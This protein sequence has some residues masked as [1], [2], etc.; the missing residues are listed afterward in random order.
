MSGNYPAGISQ[1]PA[2]QRVRHEESYGDLAIVL[3]V[4]SEIDGGLSTAAELTLNGVGGERLLNLFK[5][6]SH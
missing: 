3:L 5:T 6:F 2:W 1:R 4:V